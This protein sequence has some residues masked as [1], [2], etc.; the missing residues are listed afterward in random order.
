MT[1]SPPSCTPSRRSARGARGSWLRVARWSCAIVVGVGAIVV[2]GARPAAATGCADP[3]AEG[4]IRVT[5][6]VDSDATGLT[7]DCLVVPS[8]TTGLALLARRAGALGRT[9]PRYAQSGLLCAI[10]GFP[11]TGCGDRSNGGFAYWA[12]FSGTS[13]SWVYGAYNPFLRRLSDGDVEGW[14]FVGG[15]GDAGDPPPRIAPPRLGP[16]VRAV[17]PTPDAPTPAASGGRGVAAA[18]GS[19]ES[20]DAAGATATTIDQSASAPMAS[21]VGEPVDGSLAASSTSRSSATSWML[22]VTIA[23]LVLALSTGAVVRGRRDR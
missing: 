2:G 4:E 12:Y 18:S 22:V 14:R 23:V 16:A 13:G 5:I 10:D 1:A 19:T 17:S 15:A 3:L 21:I 11:A 20:V 8:G 7:S 9:A 6:V